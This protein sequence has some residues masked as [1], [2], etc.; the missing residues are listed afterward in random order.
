ME[1]K[2]IASQRFT[3]TESTGYRHLSVLN[4]R[5]DE[6]SGNSIMY[7]H[8]TNLIEFSG[9][10]YTP[11]KTGSKE[12]IILSC[13]L[14]YAQWLKPLKSE[15]KKNYHNGG[16][17]K[18]IGELNYGKK[19]GEWKFYFENG[20]LE[21][22]GKFTDGK[23]NGEWKY[24]YENGQLKQIGNWANSKATGEWKFYNEKGEL[25]K[26]ETY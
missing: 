13:L 3:L 9:E 11:E 26:K 6:I 12:N 7:D 24:Y 21:T 18:E 16:K 25:T 1:R 15:T 10:T 14:V 23:Q 22:I 19:S 8:K 4:V 17:L 5:V 2:K 20:Q